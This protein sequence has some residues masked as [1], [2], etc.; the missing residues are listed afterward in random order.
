MMAAKPISV[1]RAYSGKRVFLTG[2]SGFVGKVWLS[3]MLA[4]VPGIGKIYVLVRKK[5]SQSGFKRFEELVGSSPAFRPLHEAH[6]EDLASF[7]RDRLQVVEGDVSLPGLGIPQGRAAS[8]REKV[9]LVLNVAGLV[10]F[11]PDLRAA[12]ATNVTGAV[13]ALE[14]AKGCR[15][16]AFLHIST[17]FVCGKTHGEYVGESLSP[18]YCPLGEGFDAAE[19]YLEAQKE[20]AAGGDKKDW[21]LAAQER[22]RKWGW[23]N[24]YTYSKS[25]AE[26]L[27]Q[28]RAGKIRY[29]ILR[30][31]I[32]ESA[33]EFPFPGWNE[34]AETCTP[35]SYL[36]GSWLRH[37]TAKPKLV[38]D[39]LPVDW[40]CRGIALVGAVLMADRHLPV[41]H[42]ASSHKNPLSVGRMLELITLAHRKYYRENGRSAL[43]RL[44]LSR[45]DSVPVSQDSSFSVGRLREIAASLSRF[46]MKME[47]R[48]SGR[49][50]EVIHPLTVFANRAKWTLIKA[51]KILRVFSPFIYENNFRFR[52]DNLEFLQGE[53]PEFR[54]DPADIDWRDYILNI[55]EPGVRKWCYPILENKPVERYLPVH[56]FKLEN[57]ETD[58][59]NAELSQEAAR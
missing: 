45:W 2:A 23:P 56:P 4:K 40:V 31:A 5:K 53:E 34:G 6:G 36:A 59:A 54:C 18:N 20:I 43:E 17:A 11:E 28:E 25:L 58:G 1:Q 47:G 16:A 12:I 33:M 22:A 9:D 39:I 19:E 42:S 29:S 7:L 26:S 48:A 24:A 55:H 13:N 3:M 27:I 15:A 30:P 50:R 38:L 37:I 10:D 8:L 57:G 21:V 41:Y 49:V 14:F 32:V 52:T 46:A 51:E 44:V 35:I